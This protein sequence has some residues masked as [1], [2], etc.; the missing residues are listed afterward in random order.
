[1]PLSN[2]AGRRCRDSN[3]APFLCDRMRVTMCVW[4]CLRFRTPNLARRVIL[5]YRCKQSSTVSSLKFFADNYMLFLHFRCYKVRF[6][7][8]KLQSTIQRTVRASVTSFLSPDD[9]F[10]T[11]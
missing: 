6:H 7:N 10:R 1:M 3:G 9:K 11:N 5:T 4:M 8:I 2:L